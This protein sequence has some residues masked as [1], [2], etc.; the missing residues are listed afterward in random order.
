MILFYNK[1]TKEIFS[2]IQGRVHSQEVIDKSWVQPDDLRQEDVGKFIVPY[3]NLTEIINEPVFETR[4][5]DKTTMKI[6]KVKVGTKKVKRNIEL[7][8]DVIFS[9]EIIE[10]ENGEP[11]SNYEFNEEK[12]LLIKKKQM[13]L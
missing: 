12:L 8:P 10:I 9:K 11:L 6:E 3:K 7:V 5:T 2:V 4:I 1:K 13:V